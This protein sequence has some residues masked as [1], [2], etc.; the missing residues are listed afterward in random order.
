VDITSETSEE[1]SEVPSASR[2]PGKRPIGFLFLAVVATTLVIVAACAG[3]GEVTSEDMIG[4]WRKSGLDFRQFNEDGSYRIALAAE[5]MENSTVD[6][7]QFTLEGTL[8][9]LI[10]NADSAV[11]DEGQRGSYE[12]EVLEDGPLGEDRLQLTLVEDECS[13]RGS[14][15]DVTV[16]RLS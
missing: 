9:S 1:G 8:F 14:E 5:S 6:Q 12:L 2:S 7:G 10:S 16:V 15:G 13:R 3:N 11:C 4:T